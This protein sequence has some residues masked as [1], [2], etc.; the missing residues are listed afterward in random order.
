[1][2]R[3]GLVI[4][5]VALGLFF[6]TTLV[7]AE[8]ELTYVNL[9]R[10][11]DGYSKTKEYDKILDKKQKDYEK[12]REKKVGEVKKLQDKLSLL[13]EE[14]R[15]ARRGEL[16]DKIMQLQK[17]DRSST[18]DLR[19]LK[20]EKVQEIFKDIKDA[21]QVYANKEGL[22]LVFDSRA[23]VYEN[24]SLDIT[25]QISKILNKE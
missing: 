6:M 7:Y 12:E 11:F 23:V 25:D 8:G 24:K 4:L 9:G 13:S 16:E 3:G 19:K 20:D 15:E 2:K 22:S 14:E 17:F 5:G 18:Q 21:I 10:L 1:M